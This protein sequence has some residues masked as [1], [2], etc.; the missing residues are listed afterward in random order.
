ML[1]KTRTEKPSARCGSK[2]VTSDGVTTV[3][4]PPGRGGSW[5]ADGRG[6][7]AARPS[8]TAQ[9]TRSTRRYR[10]CIAPPP[11]HPGGVPS[12][13]GGRVRAMPLPA[14]ADEDLLVREPLRVLVVDREL[15]G[16]TRLL[17]VHAM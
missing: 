12:I 6:A 4:V 9:R 11:R 13:T 5:A 7:A 10:C 16:R 3:R 14:R 2:V 1:A 17:V 8:E 15:G